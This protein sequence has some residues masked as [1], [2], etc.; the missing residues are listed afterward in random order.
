MAEI[1]EQGQIANNATFWRAGTEVKHYASRA[2]RPAEVLILARY[3]G[4]CKR[5][6]EL[7]CGA[8]RALGYFVQLGAEVHGIDISE[9]MVE[10]CRARYPSAQVQVGD[11]TRLSESVTGPFDSV[12]AADNILD[13]FDDQTRRW[14]IEQIRELLAPGG[15]LVF[16][17]HN[18]GA[19]GR[20]GHGNHA[21]SARSPSLGFL[22]GVLAS[23]SPLEL[24]RAPLRLVRRRRNRRRLGPLQY[25]A[26]DHAVL[27]DVAH[28]YALLHYYVTRDYQERQLAELGFELQE[29]LDLEG[30]PVK[31]GESG[32]TPSL[33]YVA[34]RVG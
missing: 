16:S 1:R 11:M 9:A 32:R 27:N 8:G 34:R 21:I 12:L 25:T 15:L 19:V 14:V 28:D 31:P 3:L 22:W 30:W 13:S 23:R 26:S 4:S 17:S 33:Y 2:L 6:L 20:D 29:A 5:V 10:H 24:L 7:G 18:L